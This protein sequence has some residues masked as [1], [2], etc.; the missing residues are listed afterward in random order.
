[1]VIRRGSDQR[2]SHEG[3]PNLGNRLKH[4][5][6]SSHRNCPGRGLSYSVHILA[7]QRPV[8]VVRKMP[9]CFGQS[10]NRRQ[11]QPVDCFYIMSVVVW[12]FSGIQLRED[13]IG[14]KHAMACA[15]VRVVVRTF[16]R[17][18]LNVGVAEMLLAEPPTVRDYA[19]HQNPTNLHLQC[20]LASLK[21]CMVVYGLA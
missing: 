18:V 4:F 9:C 7:A 13:E 5:R 6:L 3:R 21:C 16:S 14:K 19:S 11:N 2:V 8:S 1:M 17:H 12:A 20:R 10:S 15:R